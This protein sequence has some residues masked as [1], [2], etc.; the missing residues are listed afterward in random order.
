MARRSRFSPETPERAVAMVAELRPQHSSQWSAEVAVAEKL[1]VTPQT[2]HAWVQK[3]EQ[4]GGPRSG[5]TTDDKK[6]LK[7]LEPENK[8]L[9]RANEILKAASAFFAA[10]LDDRPKK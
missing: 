1:G 7:E 4:E 5:L 10:E 8:E 2:L 6:R 9:R 3:A